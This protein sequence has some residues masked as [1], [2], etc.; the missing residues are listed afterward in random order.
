MVLP[1][2]VTWTLFVAL[3][4][5]LRL[6]LL[7]PEA[8]LDRGTHLDWVSACGALVLAMDRTLMPP[9]A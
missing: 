1:K 9:L 2:G 7:A 6:R 5:V 4:G 3:S 8:D